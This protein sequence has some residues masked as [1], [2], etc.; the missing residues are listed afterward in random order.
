MDSAVLSLHRGATSAALHP[1]TR[2]FAADEA[3]RIAGPN[4]AITPQMLPLAVRSGLAPAQ[5]DT[6]TDGSC[7]G[8]GTP[9]T[10]AGAAA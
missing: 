7:S 1:C 9:F 8:V 10:T 6:C 4:L 3:R 2:A 5:P